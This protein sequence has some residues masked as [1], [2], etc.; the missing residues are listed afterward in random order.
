MVALET[1]HKAALYIVDFS[2]MSRI[3]QINII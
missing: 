3:I 1:I 2:H